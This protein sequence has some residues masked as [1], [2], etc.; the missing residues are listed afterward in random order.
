MNTNSI[1]RHF[2]HTFQASNKITMYSNTK[3]T[4]YASLVLRYWEEL[5]LKCMVVVII[6][7][8]YIVYPL[9]QVSKSLRESWNY[10]V[11]KRKIL[12]WNQL[13]IRVAENVDNTTNWLNN[14]KEQSP[15]WEITD[16]HLFNTF[17]TFYG[18][19]KFI[20]AFTR[21]RNPYLSW[22]R[23]FQLIPHSVS[24]KFIL[25][26]YSHIFLGL[27]VFSFL[28]VSPPQPVGTSHVPHTYY[29]I[30]RSSP[31]SW[32]DHLHSVRWGVRI[33]R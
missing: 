5:A 16:P 8:K 2:T 21:T 27:S 11:N 31:S 25:I 22:V 4:V 13:E 17:S 10:E 7:K 29:Y 18:T 33:S 24:K 28:R 9:P 15:S 23:S 32:F 12:L 26:L 19:R 30:F 20:T 3:K 6:L 1:W 14:S